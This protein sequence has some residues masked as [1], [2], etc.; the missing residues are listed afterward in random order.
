MSHFDDAK[1]LINTCKQDLPQIEEAYNQ[2]LNCRAIAPDLLIKIK[3][4]MENLRSAL[5]FA[6][7]GL[8]ARYGDQG[9]AGSKIYFPYARAGLTLTGFRRERRVETCI[10][11]LTAS[12]PDIVKRIES[13]Q[14][15][16]SN[17][18][19]WLPKFMDLCNENKHQRLSPQTRKEVKELKITSGGVEMS[20][21]GRASIMMTGGASIRVGN[22]LI[23]G[24]QVISPESPAQ[25]VGTAKQEVIT[26]VSFTF[27][28]NDEPVLPLLRSALD[29]TE[30]IVEELSQS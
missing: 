2:A 14:H 1:A 6:A 17:H 3:N 22:A 13:Y 24:G 4:Y 11:G 20:L 12:R 8:F 7:N 28:S 5:D 25:I 9:K 26:W 21:R 23:G 30:K 16:A 18:N 15:F 10:P 19:E 29:G 27:S